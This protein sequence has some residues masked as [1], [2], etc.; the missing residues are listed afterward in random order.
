MGQASKCQPLVSTAVPSFARE[1]SRGPIA[2]RDESGRIPRVLIFCPAADT[3]G[4]DECLRSVQA[5][6]SEY[7]R[8]GTEIVV[9]APGALK[10]ELPFAVI[11]NAPDLFASFGFVDEEKR[12]QA[13]VAVVDR[14][15]Q[16]DAYYTGKDL[17]ALPTES[18]IAARL[19]SAESQCPECGVPEK[20]W[21]EVA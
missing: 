15:G 3:E 4:C 9:V 1:S 10:T 2:A 7:E 8:L 13:G 17:A 16:V 11:S 14:Y 20:R 21:E 5:D 6:W 12:P 19:A 18:V